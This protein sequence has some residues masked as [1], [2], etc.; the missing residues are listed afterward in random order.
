[1]FSK[2]FGKKK[3]QNTDQ[4]F[5]IDTHVDLNTEFKTI[6]TPI[7]MRHIEHSGKAIGIA[8]ELAKLNNAKFYML[9]VSYPFGASMTDF[10]QDHQPEFE[11]FVAKQ[12]ENTGVSITPL[13]RS[14]ESAS[15]I[16]SEVAGEVGVDLI[17]MSSHDPRIAD[18]IFRSNASEV[19]L[20]TN[21]SVL[22]V[23]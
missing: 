6:L 23:R 18:H 5:D 14:H 2:L 7:D 22:V 15:A 3:K 1:M 17:V 8:A 13:F 4:S 16:I 9:T 19:A 20:H 12:A 11:A 10:P 21:C